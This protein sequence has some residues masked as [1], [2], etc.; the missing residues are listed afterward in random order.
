MSRG[1][2]TR[3]RLSSQFRVTCVG[4]FTSSRHEWGPW[5]PFDDFVEIRL[6]IGFKTRL[7][8][9]FETQPEAQT[10]RNGM[11]YYY[12]QYND[13]YDSRQ[14]SFLFFFVCG[15]WME[16]LTACGAP[17]HERPPLSM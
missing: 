9:V 4:G 10:F 3:R 8:A 2:I 14:F 15:G 17:P 12:R 5:E 16:G 6:P 7:T 11:E 13:V 1:R